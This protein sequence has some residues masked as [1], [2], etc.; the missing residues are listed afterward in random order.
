MI[1][2]GI[3]H[4]KRGDKMELLELK[5]KVIDLF[6]AD[7]ESLGEALM[8]AVME[9]KTDLFDRFYEL[10][11]GDLSVDW[12]QMIYQYYHAD[13]KEKMQDYTPKSIAEFMGLLVGEADEVIDLC[14][15]SGALTIQRW[16]QNPDQKFRLYELD[17]AVIPYLLFN[18]VIRNIDST[19]SRE[20]VLQDE[21]YEQWRITKGER[22]G[23]IACIKSAV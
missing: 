16:T 14:A 21:P 20:D 9:S 18:L 17:E 3:K 23:N 11:E 5:D 19:V 22:Y 8:S 4:P 12:M 2:T 10:V 6:G 13:R 15:G 1:Q 7:I